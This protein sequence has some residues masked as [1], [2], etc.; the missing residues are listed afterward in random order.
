MEDF[1]DTY[2]PEGNMRSYGDW[3]NAVKTNINQ[4]RSTC[5][6]PNFPSSSGNG[7]TMLKTPVLVRSLKLSN[8]GPG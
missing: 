8:I 5:F 6:P 1:V 2:T 7:H 3:K 4:A